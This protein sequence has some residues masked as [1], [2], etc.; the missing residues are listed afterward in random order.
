MFP[1]QRVG[2]K[3]LCGGK[4]NEKASAVRRQEQIP[5][6]ETAGGRSGRARNHPSHPFSLAYSKTI[7]GPSPLPF[8][9]SSCSMTFAAMSR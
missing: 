9:A 3:R 6:L 1:P 4:E 8:P 7:A 2:R 5:L